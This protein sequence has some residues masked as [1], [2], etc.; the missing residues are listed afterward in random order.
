MKLRNVVIYM[1]D[2][3]TINHGIF[4]IKNNGKVDIRKQVVASVTVMN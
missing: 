3:C 2:Q 4:L 1:G